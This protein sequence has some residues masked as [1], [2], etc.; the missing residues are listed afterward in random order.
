MAIKD[1]N[2]Q[3]PISSV[4]SGIV[5]QKPA[6]PA[7]RNA[8][9]LKAPTAEAKS[10]TEQIASV[11]NQIPNDSQEHTKYLERMRLLE[12]LYDNADEVS[13]EPLIA[14]V[15]NNDTVLG[16]EFDTKDPIDVA[17][18][19]FRRQN[20]TD[21]EVTAEFEND[22][23]TPLI[24]NPR[25]PSQAGRDRNIPNAVIDDGFKIPTFKLSKE[26]ART[27]LAKNI[28]T[29]SE[30]YAQDAG[31]DAKDL[32]KV[33]GGIAT[34][35]SR[36][37]VLRSVSGTKY[38]SSAGGAFHYLNGTIAGE[39]RQ[40]MSDPRISGR[41]AALSVSVNDGVSKSEAWVL[42]E[43]DVLAGSVLARRI[44]ETVR[45]NPEL[46][47][48][49][50]ALTTRVYQAHNLGDAGARALA[51][52]GRQALESLDHR[53]DDNNPMF[54]KNT[55]SDAE[56]NAR[57][58]KFVAGAIAS[59]NPLIDVAF[60]SSPQPTMVAALKRNEPAGLL[61]PAPS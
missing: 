19:Q 12:I 2:T 18:A 59:A 55:S 36:F 25:I 23:F 35:E 58:R 1:K 16:Q 3:S 13:K 38:V 46:R 10:K 49:I 11:A 6:G 7:Q 28:R 60:S 57:Y 56:I 50:E 37:G 5:A 32:A 26:Q 44:V 21:R 33:M 29:V 34:I 31:M 53:A 54:F 42:K 40:S 51:R 30:M 15:K 4:A 43:D 14:W 48:D 24:I 39:V 41:V 47:N 61:H 52:G 20:T 45:R 9:P 27:D 22:N 17:H 8:A